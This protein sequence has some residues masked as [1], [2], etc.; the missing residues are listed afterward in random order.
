MADA[1]L[2]LPNGS[3]LCATYTRARLADGSLMLNLVRVVPSRNETS[4]RIG[5][6]LALSRTSKQIVLQELAAMELARVTP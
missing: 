5:R 4:Q 3:L 1:I 6:P 2:V